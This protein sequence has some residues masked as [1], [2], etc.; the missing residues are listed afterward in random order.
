MRIRCFGVHSFHFTSF[1]L[2]AV[3]QIVAGRHTSSLPGSH[4]YT[5]EG[6]VAPALADVC[7][8]IHET[9]NSTAK[10]GS[11]N[12]TSLRR[13]RATEPGPRSN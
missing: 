9:P 1:G 11:T 10:A 7:P 12:G 8:L 5:E 2:L 13:K 6:K 4:G 3:H